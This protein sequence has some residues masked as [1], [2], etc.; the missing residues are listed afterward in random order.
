MSEFPTGPLLGILRRI[1]PRPLLGVFVVAVLSYGVAWLL[2]KWYEA[3]TTIL[4]P[5]EGGDSFGVIASL[6]EASALSKVGLLSSNSTS[7]L[8]QEIL[9]SR[10]VREPLIEKYDLKKRYGE[11]N[12]DLC[13]RELGSHVKTDVL[14]SQ[15]IVLEVEDKDPKIAAALANDMV[16]GLDRVYREARTQKADR[17]REYLDGQLVDAQNRLRDAEAKLTAYERQY[18]FV[19][20]ASDAALQGAADIVSRK[21][22]LQ[23][24]RTWMQSYSGREN[25]ALQAVNTELA[26][27]EREI[28]RLPGIKQEAARL[29]L[30]VEIQRRVY[31]LLNAQLEEARL[32]GSRTISTI[33][34]LDPAR[35]PTIKS[36]PRRM[37]IVAVAAG[38][39]GLA[40]AVWAARRARRELMAAGYLES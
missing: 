29:N 22:A 6:V 38:I 25:P 24:R 32:E 35:P 12:L 33:S 34:V 21:L 14:R 16:T 18:G 39:A 31:T 11:P 19:A 4:P 1:L 28:A 7:D 40:V 3:K 30:D 23:V 36:R 20:S 27:L 8:F 10:R 5:D 26:A 13:L 9:E 2:P 37:I 17:A 15:I